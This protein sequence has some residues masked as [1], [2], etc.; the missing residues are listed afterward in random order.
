M[1]RYDSRGRWDSLLKPIEEE[2][3]FVIEEYIEGDED[4]YS[5]NPVRSTGDGK[6][7]PL[8]EIEDRHLLNIEKF[9]EKKIG[10]M[11]EV[12][13]MVDEGHANPGPEIAEAE[14]RENVVAQEIKRRGLFVMDTDV[15][16]DV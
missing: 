14:W 7:I 15:K 2:E 1:G 13:A 4:N 3:P 11:E 10:E 9:L 16:E 12:A 8:W 6:Q 5:D